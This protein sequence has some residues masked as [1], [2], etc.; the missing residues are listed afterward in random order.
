MKITPLP[1]ERD[2]FN[3][4]GSTLSGGEVPVW[5]NASN[6]W[7]PGTAGVTDH[8]ALTG[9]ADDDHSAYLK[10]IEGGQDTISA[11]GNMGATET[12]DP[13]AGNV[14]TATAN[15]ACTVTLSAPV[16]SGAATLELYVTQDGTGGWDLT[17][18]GSVVWPGGVDPVP[19]TTAST[20]TRYVLE[21]LDGGTTWYGVMVGAGGTAATTVT[22]ETTWGISPAVGTDTEYARQD[23]THGSPAEPVTAPGSDHEHIDNLAFSGDGSTTAFELPAAPFDA[24]SVAAFVSGV[25]TGVTLSGGLLTTMTFA[26]PPGSGTDNINV[27]LAAAVA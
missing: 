13:T 18:P 16:G 8:G 23:H 3:I 22:D 26:S 1:R 4:F 2:L 7:V 20:L 5:S 12:F 11:H 19:D 6:T 27:D 25:R 21:T 24:Y 9:L 17:W 10:K 14:H 15:A